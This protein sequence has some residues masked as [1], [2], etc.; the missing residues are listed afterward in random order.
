MTTNT[1]LRCANSAMFQRGTNE[2][3]LLDTGNYPSYS[4]YLNETWTYNGSTNTWTN[5]GTT[6]IDANGPLPGRSQHT[7]VYDGYNVM[8]FGG[9]G[10]SSTAG[11]FNDT[12]TWNG[13]SWTK[14]AP[15]NSPFGRFDAQAAFITGVGTVMFGGF[16]GA[17]NGVYLNETW[18]WDGSGLTWTKL[19]PTTSPSARIQHCMASNGTLA[20]MFGGVISSGEFKNDTWSFNGAVWTQLSPATSPSVRGGS[21][22]SYDSVNNIFVLF[23]GMNEYNYLPETWTFNGTTW[24]Q[25]AVPAGT[26]PSGKNFAQMCFDTHAGKTI[27]FGGISATS[28]YPSNET[29]AFD[30][31]ALTWALK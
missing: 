11:V 18:E 26:G 14:R 9:Q 20:Y 8:L 17:G 3:V 23:G 25:V 1:P 30:G 10:G 4:S 24:T 5:T 28:N 19:S 12:W 6:L 2:T 16:G 7:M 21:V 15:T 22:M 13:T 31:S 29:W 27:L